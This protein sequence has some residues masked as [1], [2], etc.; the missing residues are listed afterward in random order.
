MPG[1]MPACFNLS[2]PPIGQAAAFAAPRRIFGDLRE[3]GEICRS[4]RRRGARRG[5]CQSSVLLLVH[6][7][8]NGWRS[9]Q[10]FFAIARPSVFTPLEV[11]DLIFVAFERAVKRGRR[12]T[13]S[14]W[15]FSPL[16]GL[17]CNLRP[18]IM[19]ASASWKLFKRTIVVAANKTRR[20]YCSLVT[21]LTS[22]ISCKAWVTEAKKSCSSSA[23]P[24]SII[25][26]SLRCWVM[27]VMP[28]SSRGNR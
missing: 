25:L 3:A 8:W 17:K 16:H 18:S 28:H 21:S 9:D 26:R 1:K 7:H 15:N 5:R 6:G 13:S 4:H 27:T 23:W 24:P 11:V 2:A 14:A 20:G 19:F 22:C 10:P 12:H